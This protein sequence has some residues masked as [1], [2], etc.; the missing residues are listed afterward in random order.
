LNV[1]TVLV[2]HFFCFI[3]PGCLI[4]KTGI[5][6]VT[7]PLKD[8]THV[9]HVDLSSNGLNEYGATQIAEV[10]RLSKSLRTLSLD[11]EAPDTVG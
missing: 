7:R 11:G 5:A 1:P 2:H 9:R 3:A 8:N 10:L 4:G 6:D